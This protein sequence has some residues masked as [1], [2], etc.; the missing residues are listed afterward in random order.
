MSKNSTENTCVRVPFLTKLQALQLCEKRDCDIGIF[1]Q[2]FRH[3]PEHLFLQLQR[4]LLDLGPIK[5]SVSKTSPRW[6]LN[7]IN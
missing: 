4:L 7:G 2:I 1:L 6:L 3:F 5:T